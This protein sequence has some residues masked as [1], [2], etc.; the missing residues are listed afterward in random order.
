MAQA[1]KSR[2]YVKLPV[3]VKGIY[4]WLYNK[5]DIYDF[6]DNQLWV[7]CITLGFHKKLVDSV[8]TE[9]KPGQQV[10][11][12]GGTVGLQ[13]EE[14]AYEIG[15]SGELTLIDNKKKQKKRRGQKDAEVY[16]NIK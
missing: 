1:I 15:D 9:L 16:N 12:F 6:F 10:L 3:N 4:D 8:A 13:I 2:E 5:K 11:Q 7:N 14:A